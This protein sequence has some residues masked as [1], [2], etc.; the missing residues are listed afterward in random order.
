MS[1]I[2]TNIVLD[3]ITLALRTAFPDSQ[4]ESNRIE[5]GLVSPAFI[6]LL[7]SE[8][9]TARVGRHWHRR[10]RFDISY[11]PKEKSEECYDVA[12]EFYGVL[13]FITLPGEDLLPGVDISF[14]V[15][16]NILHFFISYSHY[17]SADIDEEAMEDMIIMQ[18]GLI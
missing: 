12:N 15:T 2:S 7:V 5:Q 11:F 6:V 14:E 10:T 17:V 9:Q 4:I 18:G 3:G 16:E 13:E 8:E 1:V